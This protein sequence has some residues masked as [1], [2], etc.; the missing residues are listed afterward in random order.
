MQKKDKH[1]EDIYLAKWLADEI[2]DTKL[3]ELV[4]ENDYI[5]FQKIKKGIEAFDVLEK[6][7]E[8]SFSALKLPINKTTKVR[9]LYIKWIASIAAAVLLL[10]VVNQFFNENI[11]SEYAK[12]GHHKNIALLDGSEVLLNGNSTISYNKSKWDK[13]RIV[14][15]K[16]EALF[17]VKKGKKFTVHTSNGNVTVLGTE[18][19]VKSIADF[20]EVTCFSGKVKI[21]QNNK[22]YVLKAKDV[23]QKINGNLAEIKQTK[24][25]YPDWKDNETTLKSIPIKYVLL[26]LENQYDLKFENNTIDPN[27]LFTGSFPNDNQHVALKTVFEAL[28]I[29]YKVKNNKVTLDHQ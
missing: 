8:E 20:F 11:V 14:F 1:T 24:A 6:P 7:L 4:S 28:Q 23:F 22:E 12:K 9:Q 15:L 26:I 2:S 21:I 27:I 25:L 10:F 19:N 18:F 17:K 29:K 16:G 13:E 3:K 5:A